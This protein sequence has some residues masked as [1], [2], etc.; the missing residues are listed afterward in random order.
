MTTAT[1]TDSAPQ[2]AKDAPPPDRLVWVDLEMTGL[3]PEKDVILE[4]AVILT[5]REL[6][7]VREWEPWVVHQPDAILDGMDKWNTRTHSESGLIDKC[8]ASKLS[9]AA[10]ERAIIKEL[11]Q[12]VDKHRSPMCGNSIC[13]DR[14]FM[15]R[16]MPLLEDYFHYRNFDVSAFKIAAQLYYPKLFAEVKGK[17]PASHQALDDIRASIEEMKFYRRQMLLPPAL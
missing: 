13:Q 10:A 14:R 15:A 4:A 7:I 12:H 8:R 11:K 1:P 5:D 17:K 3:V 16:H 9:V 2:G 6:N